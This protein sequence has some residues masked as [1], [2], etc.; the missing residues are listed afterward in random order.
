MHTS[1]LA[2]DKLQNGTTP[3]NMHITEREKDLGIMEEKIQKGLAK[4]IKRRKHKQKYYLIKKFKSSTLD[5]G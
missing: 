2:H 3:S 5:E 4:G 1:Q